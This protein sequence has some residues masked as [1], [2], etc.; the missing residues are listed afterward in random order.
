[1]SP[2]HLCHSSV[3]GGMSS[4]F[5]Y[6]SGENEESW[7]GVPPRPM[8]CRYVVMPLSSWWNDMTPRN[9][10]WNEWSAAMMISMSH[11][12]DCGRFPPGLCIPPHTRPHRWSLRFPQVPGRT[13]FVPLICD[14]RLETILQVC[15]PRFNG[16]ISIDRHEKPMTKAQW[17]VMNDWWKWK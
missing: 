13:T 2:T 10:L 7:A 15:C 1:M 16:V 11:M 12:E 14:G 5:V 9:R 8:T 6:N 3:I 4:C 17:S